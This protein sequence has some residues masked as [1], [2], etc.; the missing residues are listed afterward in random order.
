M[1]ALTRGDHPA[2]LFGADLTYKWKPVR[3]GEFHSVVLGGELFW[4]DRR[5]ADDAGAEQHATPLAWY[6]FAQVQTSWHT[7]LGGRYD[8][9]QD[10]VD[11]SIT[12]RV[13]AGYLSYYTS[14]FLPAARLRAPLERPGHRRR[15]RHRPRRG[16]HRLRLPP[17]RAL[18]GQP[19]RNRAPR[20]SGSASAGYL[21][22]AHLRP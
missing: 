3:A 21:P 17:D 19:L 18:L 6:A 5:F 15:H 1:E 2:R 8:F 9:A 7:Y 14:E 22:T 20:G 12:T 10:P 11:D 13:A 16:Q 4:A